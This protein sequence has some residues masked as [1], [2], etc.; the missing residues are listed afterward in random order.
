MSLL[1]KL[2]CSPQCLQCRLP[3]AFL[4]IFLHSMGK[5]NKNKN[6]LHCLCL[7][8]RSTYTTHMQTAWRRQ[9]IQACTVELHVGRGDDLGYYLSERTIRESL[10]RETIRYG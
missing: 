2:Q 6:K 9:I 1:C 8:G 7:L 5:K 10:S 4:Y 3:K